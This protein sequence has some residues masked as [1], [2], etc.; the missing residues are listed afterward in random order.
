M[1]SVT[2]ILS[3]ISD[4]L[5]TYV[6]II[7]LLGC[8]LYLSFRTKFV[9]VR[10]FLESFRLL[11]EKKSNTS[12]I[13]SFQALMIATASRVGTGN[14][15]GV[16]SALVIG[17]P[18]ALLWMWITALLGASSACIECILAQIYKV[19]NADG[20]FRGGPSYYIHRLS[21]QKGLGILFSVLLILCFSFGFN[22]LQAFNFSSSFENYI[23]NYQ[24]S[25]WPYIVGILLSFL[26][27]LTILKGA[28]SIGIMSSVLVPI[29]SVI[30]IG[31]ALYVTI[32]NLSK[33]PTIFKLMVSNA[34][35][36]KA[37]FGGF[38]SS[39]LLLGVKRGLF[40]NEA[41]MGSAPNA[42]A[43]ADV[44]HPAEQGISQI[45]SVL[46]DTLIGT[47]TAFLILSSGI[48]L[49]ASYGA[50]NVV[51]QALISQFGKTFGVN[52]ISLSIFLFSFSSIIGNY[53]YAESNILYIFNSTKALN[54][55]RIIC[56][57]PIFI[58]TVVSS[59]IAW[60]IADICMGLMAIVNIIFVLRGSKQAI[61]CLDDYNKLKK[62]NKPIKFIAQT[63]GI[64][65][66][67]WN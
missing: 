52:F 56:M 65:S 19:R 13:S 66:T 50:L 37:I 22:G 38:F 28:K 31:V 32:I 1:L 12:G 29:M 60:N 42:A 6:L 24:N 2:S 47:S 10:C 3:T 26:F 11:S 27:L 14:I 35:D 51:Q 9:Q 63:F 33:L 34:F 58:G 40:S 39:A 55:F 49:N 59:E 15:V 64:N 41:G 67:L 46:I 7:L 44:A 5:Y 18:G 17:G 36:F 4:S 16:A 23:P 57:A 61:T 48:E 53:Y 21:G 43:T 20:T 30:Y 8:G 45:F 25:F 54:L 62:C